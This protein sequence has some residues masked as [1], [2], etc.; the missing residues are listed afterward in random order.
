MCDFSGWFELIIAELIKPNKNKIK[1]L[2]KS[3]F[4]TSHD[5]TDVA[6]VTDVALIFAIF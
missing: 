4:Y 6:S 2:I 1:Q 3:S 5:V